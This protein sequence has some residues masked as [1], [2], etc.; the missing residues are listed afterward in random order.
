[1]LRLNTDLESYIDCIADELCIDHWLERV[2]E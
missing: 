2:A 1:M